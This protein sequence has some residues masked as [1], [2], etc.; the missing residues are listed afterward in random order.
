[1][2]ALDYCIGEA[3]APVFHRA[4]VLLEEMSMVVYIFEL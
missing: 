4:A 3:R 2:P 1:M